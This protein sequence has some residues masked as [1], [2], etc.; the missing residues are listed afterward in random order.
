MMR[1]NTAIFFFC[2]GLGWALVSSPVQAQPTLTSITPGA[3]QPGKT[4]E[5]VLRGT[6]LQ[7]A[8]RV[9]TSF[10]A[11]VELAE[12]PADAKD[13]KERGCKIT[14]PA[15]AS[16]GIGGMMLGSAGGTSEVL[17]VNI[18][19]LPSVAEAGNNGVS[20][21]AQL[22]TLPT[23]VDGTSSGKAFDYF[24]FTAKAGQRVSFEVVASRTGSAFDPVIRLL[25]AE[26]KELVYIDDGA[27]LGA[28]C[29]FEYR[30]TADGDYLL[31]MYD[32]Q[33]R[34]GLPYRLRLGDFPLVATAYPLGARLGS[35]T[36]LRFTGP[37]DEAG[38]ELLLRVPDSVPDGRFPVSI[39]Y[40]NGQSSAGAV[41]ATSA[42]P[43]AMETEPNN[44]AKTAN[45]V[46][47]P[48]A[49]NG[50]IQESGDRDCFRFAGVK[51]QLIHCQA[52]TVSLGS[53]CLAML[54]L[55]DGEGRKLAESNPAAGDELELAH[56]LPADGMYVIQVEE[57]LRRA[58]KDFAYRVQL[59]TDA[60]FSLSLKN[61]PK[62]PNRFVTPVADGGFALDV[63]SPRRGY[64]GPIQLS[65]E[66][67]GDRYR[68][69]T[70]EI[71]AKAANQRVVIAV[72]GATQ[73]GELHA[74]RLVG[75]TAET[76]GP[77]V[78]LTTGTL[79]RAKFP[80]LPQIPA[81]MDG[82]LFVA[83]GAAADPLYALTVPA[84]VSVPATGTTTATFSVAL[85]RKH[86][87]F[88]G[89][90]NIQVQGLPAGYSAAVKA[91]GDR[92]D[93]TL[94]GPAEAWTVGTLLN[95]LI[96]GELNG[97]LQIVERPVKLVAP[98]S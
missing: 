9:W 34:G 74:L 19:D 24:R 7:G 8:L 4:T 88:K 42:L 52:L 30:F 40:P 59:R 47:L 48:S 69:L 70:P 41:L 53:P 94:T 79:M 6:N 90:L 33:Y 82:V 95:L 29:R 67:A 62:L 26:G 44:D 3:V 28:D 31:E 76:N 54:S 55:L 5:V 13:V 64:D 17:A 97:R 71:A 73:P 92:Y 66:G 83:A 45:E 81:W 38:L 87:D 16:V 56:T 61:D 36:Q 86:K 14:L 27:G 2:A 25:T 37:A 12:L 46:T 15:E 43:E 11:Q 91:E 60:G 57:L 35:T 39:K 98:A 93:V 89:A 21:Q 1:L 75:R 50:V 72:T 32:N 80:V 10:P 85:E 77:S 18:D 49:L 96:E 58:G 63:Q 22:L 23:A 20:A 68:L 78:L 51:G 84:E 65:L